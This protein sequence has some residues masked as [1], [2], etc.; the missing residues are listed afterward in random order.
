MNMKVWKWLSTPNQDSGP[1][2]LIVKVAL[3]IKQRKRLETPNLEIGSQW[4]M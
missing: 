1:K 2:R 3:N 4:L